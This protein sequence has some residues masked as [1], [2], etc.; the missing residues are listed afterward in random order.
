MTAVVDLDAEK[1]TGLPPSCKLALYVIEE[2][3]PIG[4]QTLIAETTLP[5]RTVDTAVARLR[6]VGCIESH[7]DPADGR[8]CYYEITDD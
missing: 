5:E 7:S 4:R 3:Q 6:D 1:T 8:K 2:K